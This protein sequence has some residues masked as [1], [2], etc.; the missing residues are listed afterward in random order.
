MRRQIIF[1]SGVVAL[2]LLIFSC[3][4]DSDYQ[5]IDTGSEYYPNEIGYY[6]VYDVD[7]TYYDDFNHTI[8][9]DTFQIK[10]VFESSFLDQQNREARRIERWYKYNDT[11]EWVLKDVWHSVK[12][13]FRVEKIEENERF[14]R[15]I[16]PISEYS[17]WDGNAMN[18]KGYQKYEFDNVNNSFS[19]D[20]FTFDSTCKV[21][22][23]NSSNLIDEKL[24]YE[25]YA[26]HIG[27][28]YKKYKVIKKDYVTSQIVSGVD[29]VWRY[30]SSG[31]IN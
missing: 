1:L 26:K 12:T 13:N 11:S 24:Q 10:E 31:I 21:L 28:V 7:S 3:R 17:S 23:A 30:N 18:D 14:V 25:I 9:R 15:L 19:F 22:Q 5:W 16:F 27:L 29:Y 8:F 4:K 20:T 2:S 6:I